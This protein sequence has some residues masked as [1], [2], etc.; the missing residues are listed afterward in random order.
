M[1]DRNGNEIK[2][3]QIVKIDFVVTALYGESDYCNVRLESV[4]PMPGNG[5]YICESAVN[6]KQVEIVDLNAEPQPFD[7]KGNFIRPPKE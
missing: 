6:T 7:D 4:H 5:T 2:L 1:H 3:G